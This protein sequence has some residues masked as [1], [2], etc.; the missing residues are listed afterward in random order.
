MEGR[1][2][3]PFG[4]KGIFYLLMGQAKKEIPPV[5]KS[6]FKKLD[7]RYIQK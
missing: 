4:G 7:S 2:R 1:E 3:N 6:L 5:A